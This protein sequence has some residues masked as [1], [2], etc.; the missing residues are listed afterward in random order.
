MKSLLLFVVGAA[1]LALSLPSEAQAKDLVEGKFAH[2]VFFW[3]KEP[4][5]AE[6]RE[7]F[8]SALREMKKI[9][10]IQASY[11]GKPAGTPRDVV[12][13]SWT[14]DWLVTFKDKAGWQIYNDHPI[15]K[16]FIEKAG[17]LWERVLVYD[18]VPQD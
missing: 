2:H 4:D 3:L 1:V 13:N 9:P 18:T 6:H 14:F 10:T 7:Q 15:H 11:I 17:D 12:D 16:E 8:L 5:N